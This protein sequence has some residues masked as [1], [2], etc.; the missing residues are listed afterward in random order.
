VNIRHINGV[1]SMNSIYAGSSRESTLFALGPAVGTLT[2]ELGPLSQQIIR[3]GS[4]M[5]YTTTLATA[6]NLLTPNITTVATDLNANPNN[7]ANNGLVHVV[8]SAPIVF[9]KQTIPNKNVNT[10]IQAITSSNA[11][12]SSLAGGQK[13]TS[14]GVMADVFKYLS[15]GDY[16]ALQVKYVPF[17]TNYFGNS[18]A[19]VTNQTITRSSNVSATDYSAKRVNPT[20][21][22]TIGYLGATGNSFPAGYV[23]TI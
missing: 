20:E 2:I 13:L 4:N 7:S 1:I 22:A 14:T 23:M 5:I 9:Q 15:Y 16:T 19:Y 11:S 8:A 21:A 3:G 10:T 18:V 12:E 17:C 6:S